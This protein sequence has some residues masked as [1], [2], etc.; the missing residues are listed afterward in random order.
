[1]KKTLAFVFA[2]LMCFTLFAGCGSSAPTPAD[3][4]ANPSAEGAAEAPANTTEEE[5]HEH[6]IQIGHIDACLPTRSPSSPMEKSRSRS[7]APPDS[8]MRRKW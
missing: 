6:S 2:V 4:P 3:T 5:I 1:M 7:S 8:A